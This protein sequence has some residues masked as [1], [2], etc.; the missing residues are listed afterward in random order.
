MISVVFQDFSLPALTL[1]N[2]ISGKDEYDMEKELNIFHKIGID[3]W[4]TK[5]NVSFDQ[6]LYND[7]SD[8]GVEISGG[9][10]QKIAIARAVYKDAPFIILDEPTAALDP[11]AEEAIFNDFHQL[12]NEKTCIFISH[13]LYSCK[14]CD[15]IL[16]LSKGRAVQKGT[17]KDLLS[18][19]G[20]YKQLWDLQA[21]MYNEIC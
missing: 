10:S 13:R 1:G 16:V 3:K 5:L 7:F 19:S 8:T 17:H 14:V 11:I 9:E 15:F 6:Y 20:V 18:C 4:M 12:Y 2:V 21:S